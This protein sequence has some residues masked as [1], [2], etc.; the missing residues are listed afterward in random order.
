MGGTH[1]ETLFGQDQFA[2]KVKDALQDEAGPVPNVHNDLPVIKQ[3]YIKGGQDMPVILLTV[4]SAS[5]SDTGVMP[6]GCP[7]NI[8]VGAQRA[9]SY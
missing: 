1:G 5:T 7:V 2:Q 8:C 9:V 4:E 6:E 3:L